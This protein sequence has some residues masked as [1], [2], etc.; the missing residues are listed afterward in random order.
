MDLLATQSSLFSK[1]SLRAFWVGT[2]L[3]LVVLATVVV[4]P[5]WLS[6]Q[7]RLEVLRSHVAQIARLAA[8]VVDGD[9]HRQLLDQ[10]NFGES[11]YEQAQAPLVAFHSSSPEI[12]YAYTMVDRGGDTRFVLD[13]AN[14]PRLKTQRR[15]VPSEYFEEFKLKPEY[16]D[17]WLDRLRLGEAYVTPGFQH[18][19]YGYF[20]TG[21]A[22]IYDRAGRYSGFVGVDFAIDYYVAQERRF[23]WIAYGSFTAAVGLSLLIGFLVSRHY[24]D[25]ENRIDFH[26]NESL[27]DG[28]TELLNRRGAMRAVEQRLAQSG[29]GHAVMLVDIDDFKTINDSYGHATGDNVL[30]SV[31]DA[32]RQSVRETDIVARLGGD[33]FLIFAP[34]CNW[35]VA[36]DIARRVIDS[37]RG[38]NDALVCSHFSVSIGIC[39]EAPSPSAFEALYRWADEALYRAKSAGKGRYAFF[40]PVA[41]SVTDLADS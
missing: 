38:Y 4:I 24:F 1:L 10:A 31:A 32:L 21:H 3:S 35:E 36:R 33:E 26:F 15:L 7:A 20:L 29:D 37:V 17:G 12:Y 6:K 2:L 18:D 13:T 23:E 11:L 27:R 40:R 30:L 39:A 8:S 28:L 9:L 25:V 19:N 22:P 34:H 16:E 5:Q 41:P 14:S